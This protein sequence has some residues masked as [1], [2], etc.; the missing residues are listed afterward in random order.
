MNLHIG[1]RNLILN[2]ISYPS[3][4]PSQKIFN[5][6]FGTISYDYQKLFIIN[7]LNLGRK[8]MNPN[9]IEELK[10]LKK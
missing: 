7:R 4:C 10:F 8:F 2:K 3:W 6:D 9:V 1:C 5:E